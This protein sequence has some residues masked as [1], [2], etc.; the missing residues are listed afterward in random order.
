MRYI[1]SIA[2]LAITA[3]STALAAPTVS[4]S[5]ETAANV[6]GAVFG[7]LDKT[8]QMDLTG[9]NGKVEQVDLPKNTRVECAAG[10]PDACGECIPHKFRSRANPAAR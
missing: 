4:K 9:V 3:A 2:L 5:D 6:K 1:P 10:S 8:N 7:T